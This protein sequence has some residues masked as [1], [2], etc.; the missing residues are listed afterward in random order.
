MSA[1]GTIE[2]AEASNSQ[3]SAIKSEPLR[4]LKSSRKALALITLLLASLSLAW[5]VY[6]AYEQRVE[7]Q[8][9]HEQGYGSPC[10]L[11]SF[12]H[13]PVRL[14]IEVFIIIL[15][16]GTLLR[17]VKGALLTSVG[18]FGAGCIY[19]LWWQDY[20]RLARIV[21]SETDL[22]L[23]RDACRGYLYGGNYFDVSV[24]ILLLVL[25]VLYGSWTLKWL[26]RY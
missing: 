8:R 19:V 12:L 18:L 10:D 1:H 9:M 11:G 2:I 16:V 13:S 20:F 22:R 7:S 6:Q 4:V 17:G 25:I 15:F 23:L 3:G 24:A 14:I 5:Q 21:E 26:F